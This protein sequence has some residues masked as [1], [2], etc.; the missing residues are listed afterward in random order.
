MQAEA[1]II[2]NNELVFQN[3]E[4][5]KRAAELIIANKE[6]AF[7]N[8]E[9]EKRAAELIIANKELAFQNEEKG[10]R[11]AE[12]T[13]ANRELAFQNDEKGK[14]A[15]EL[16]VA[17][18]ELAFQNEEKGKRA[19][20]LT[21]ANKELAFQ[22]DEKGK[23]AAE[24]TIA[25][26]E[27]A[28]QNEEKEKRA[29]ELTIANKELAFQNEEKG[30][31]A[32]ELTIANEELAFQND[33]KGK[34]AA[35]LT[36][37]NKELAFQ[38]EEKE[39]RASELTIANDELAFQNEEKGKRAAELTIANKE[40]A[41]QN[42]EKEKRAS[43]LTI[44]NREL[45]KAEDG[46]RQLNEELEQKVIQ[47]TAQFETVNKELESFSYSVA[48]DLRTPLRAVHGYARIL[49]EDHS[50]HLSGEAHRVMSNIMVYAIKMGKLIDDLLTFSRLGRK[51]LVK[52]T[53]PM[54]DMVL[55]LCQEVKS[56]HP[57]RNIEIT[58]H[59][60]Q[61]VQGDSI[62]IK[63][64]WLNLVSNAVKYSKLKKTTRIEIGCGVLGD[65][66]DYYVK[67]NGAGFDMRY[68]SKLFGVF[69]RLHSDETFEGTGVGLAIVHRIISKHGGRVWA[70][71][72][73][74]EGAIFNFSLPRNTPA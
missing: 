16:M 25:N 48:H 32:A 73:V 65:E 71:G 30:K 29:S 23:R 41:F 40:L 1:L 59:P 45:K 19:A 49:M 18:K 70:E 56:E 22:N 5:E 67:D 42:V 8:E 46:I 9:K 28:F 62:T 38:N 69:Q 74:N 37:A 27:L 33:E 53:I 31:R 57:N 13:I 14:R 26:K 15:A 20:E 54:H 51:E 6:L 17:N 11:A 44:A 21:I 39:K 72:K 63:Q 7:Q 50:A 66:V 47:R 55:S 12:L 3:A 60:L 2:A 68:A 24:L 58:V 10:K 43:E 52:V 61:S 64:V 36:I 34:R 35:E 4:K